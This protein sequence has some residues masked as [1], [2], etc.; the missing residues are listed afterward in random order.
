[1]STLFDISIR[2]NQID[3][4]RRT[5]PGT[6]ARASAHACA[7]SVAQLTCPTLCVS[8]LKSRSSP[9]TSS[10]CCRR[11]LAALSSTSVARTCAEGRGG[12]VMEMV[13][14]FR[15]LLDRQNGNGEARTSSILTFACSTDS[16][17]LRCAASTCCSSSCSTWASARR[18]R[19]VSQGATHLALKKQVRRGAPAFGRRSLSAARW[20]PAAGHRDALPALPL[21]ARMLTT[22]VSTRAQHPKQPSTPCG[23]AARTRRARSMDPRTRA[24]SHSGG[25]HPLG[26]IRVL[27]APSAP[28]QGHGR[29]ARLRL[30]RGVKVYLL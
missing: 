15:I 30:V 11:L 21:P 3:L 27:E 26:L 20:T 23:R 6:C 8:L 17:A 2:R 13:V 14:G 28:E 24:A 22:A 9:R 16:D 5:Q 19:G 7:D 1:M 12:G 10:T 29:E 25:P 4:Q 18:P